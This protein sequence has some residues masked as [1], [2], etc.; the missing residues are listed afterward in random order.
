MDLSKV[1]EGL[2]VKV[3]KLGDTMGFLIKP[4]H[5]DIRKV[6]VTGT[7]VGYVPGHGGDVWFVKHDGEENVVGAYMFDEFEEA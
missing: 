4:K 3:T 2:K 5:L 1:K 7:V 6:G